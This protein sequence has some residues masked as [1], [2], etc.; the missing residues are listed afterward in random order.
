MMLCRIR[1]IK[2]RKFLRFYGGL[3]QDTEQLKKSPK[4]YDKEHKY[5]DLLRRKNFAA[6]VNL[7][8]AE[9]ISEN[10]VDLAEEGFIKIKP[11]LDY[12][13]NTLA[14]TE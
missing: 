13:N 8:A 11:L 2:D 12:I 14:F 4:G 7:S 5:L 9:V 6:T 1:I 3:N 10:F